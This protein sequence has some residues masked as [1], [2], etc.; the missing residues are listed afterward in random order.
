[1]T[2]SQCSF[3]FSIRTIV[4]PL[5]CFCSFT[6]W[7]RFDSVLSSTTQRNNYILR[8]TNKCSVITFLP[9]DNVII[10]NQKIYICAVT[11]VTPPP[12]LE[13]QVSYM[14][15]SLNINTYNKKVFKM[16]RLINKKTCH[17][18]NN[19]V[20]KILFFFLVKSH[21]EFGSTIRSPSYSP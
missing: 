15:F 6:D 1:M 18:K 12:P 2:L 8:S 16:L 9:S 21:I 11:R 20:L 14:Y 4:W 3:L 7:S 5:Y 17:L 13:T 19:H 10:Y